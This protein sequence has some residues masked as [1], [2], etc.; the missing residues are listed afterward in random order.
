MGLLLH[1]WAQARGSDDQK[2]PSEYF[3]NQ[4]YTTFFND[5]VGGHILSW[6]GQDNCMWSSDFPHGRHHSHVLAP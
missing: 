1:H 5:A 6:W 3:H 2:R 4:I